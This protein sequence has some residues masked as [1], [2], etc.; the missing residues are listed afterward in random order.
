MSLKKLLLG[1]GITLLLTLTAVAG[2]EVKNKSQMKFGGAV[3][4]VVGLFGGKS[5]REGVVSTTVVAGNRKLTRTEDQGQIIDLDEEK[6]YE[7]NWKKKS[8]KV[9][10]FEEMRRQMEEAARKLEQQSGDP[11][12][13]GPGDRA[14][15]MEIDFQLEESG[16]TRQINGFECSEVVMTITI[17]EQGK[18]L[19][20]AGGTVMTSN[21]WLSDDL[22]ALAEVQDFDRRY[23]EKMATTLL[24][25]EQQ[26]A[27]FT[28]MYPALK[29]AFSRFDAEKVNVQGSPVLTVMNVESV[30]PKGAAV[31]SAQSEESSPG[32]GGLLGGFGKKLGK[33]KP[34]EEKGPAQPGRSSLMTVNDELL[35]VTTGVGPEATALPAGFKQQ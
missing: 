4:K 17:R 29:E 5:A 13:D 9:M 11:A 19:E 26:M 16:Q 10:T 18:T 32:L 34:A 8:Y 31:E 27:A 6:I 3:G 35:S 12:A 1:G 24:G 25:S 7:V 30:A 21:L 15:Q 22:D 20:E 14:R 23:A 28:A 33:K 2:V